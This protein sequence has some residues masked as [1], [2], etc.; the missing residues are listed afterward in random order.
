[1]AN[2]KSTRIYGGLGKP[3]RTRSKRKKKKHRM[4]KARKSDGWQRRRS[5]KLAPAIF[6][7]KQIMRNLNLKGD[8]DA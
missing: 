2:E 4:E 1:M 6:T 5:G 8:F 7:S 3:K